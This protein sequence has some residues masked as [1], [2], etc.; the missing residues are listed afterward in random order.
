MPNIALNRRKVSLVVFLVAIFFTALWFGHRTSVHPQ[1]GRIYLAA[2][3]ESYAYWQ[4]AKVTVSRWVYR[5]AQKPYYDLGL[6]VGPSV[7]GWSS[8]ENSPSK[9]DGYIYM[10]NP[11]PGGGN[12][13][14]WEF[15]LGTKHR[16]SENRDFPRTF[17]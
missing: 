17:V 1:F 2:M 11:L 5:L 4:K 12:A 7:L 10:R 15:A 16:L 3:S 14:L 8:H 13:P 6:Q 9:R